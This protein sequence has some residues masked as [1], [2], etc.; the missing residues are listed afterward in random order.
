ML[1]DAD[2]LRRAGEDFAS[3]GSRRAD[4]RRHALAGALC[5]AAG[6]ARLP[7]RIR[8][9]SCNLHQG[10][11]R[12]VAEM[13]L[14]GEA[15]IGIATEALADYDELVAL[16]CY[17]WTHSVIV[18]PDAPLADEARPASD[19][20]AGAAGAVPDHHL[21][22]RLHRPQRTSTRPSKRRAGHRPGAV[23]DGRRRDQDLRGAR[24]GRG[25]HRGDRLRRGSATAH[26]R[27][28]DARHLFAIEHD[29]AGVRR[30]SFLRS[31][32]YDFIET[33]ASPLTRDVVE[34]RWPSTPGTR[35][36]I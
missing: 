29:A 1:Q 30:G 28:I 3:A 15:D 34:R 22:T 27:A 2:N 18:P 5:A 8:R 7:P 20:D 14:S 17:R 16:P 19:A 21:R 32:V 25:H 36:D 10:S 33:F 9:C 13:L 23:G 11:P 12:Q 4:D 24:H 26:L 35:F 31:Y 6:G